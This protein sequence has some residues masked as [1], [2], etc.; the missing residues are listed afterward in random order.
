MEMFHIIIMGVVFGLSMLNLKLKCWN[1]RG[2]IQRSKRLCQKI[3]FVILGAPFS[4]S[5][6]LNSTSQNITTQFASDTIS[7]AYGC[8]VA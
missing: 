5:R 7:L 1:V 4:A 3:S 2:I 8:L 6:K